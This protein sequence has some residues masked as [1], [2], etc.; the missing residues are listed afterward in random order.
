M[1]GSNAV[2]IRVL[3]PVAK[4]RLQTLTENLFHA[5]DLASAKGATWK[6]YIIKVR[7]PTSD[8]YPVT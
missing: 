6:V 8:M 4:A 5:D 1:G 7:L 3:G 2:G